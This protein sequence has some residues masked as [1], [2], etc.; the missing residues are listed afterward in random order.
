MPPTSD[1]NG[2]R[3]H[4]PSLREVVA[5]LDG[6]REAMNE[7]DQ[8]YRSQFEAVEEKGVER[9]RR[10]EDRFTAMDEK[11][12]LALTASEKAVSKAETATEKRFDAVNEFRGQLKDQAATLLPRAESDG[13]FKSYDEK[14]EDMKKEIG[15]LRE[16]RGESV[17]AKWAIGLGIS[18]AGTMIG[19][20][21]LI[22]KF[23]GQK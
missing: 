3:T 20:A 14:F 16:S 15:A 8:R 23:I 21:M 13:K 6:F 22:I 12:S 4:E 1:P 5:E 11:T 19:G 10:Y 17:G 18:V 2:G 7:R 9:D